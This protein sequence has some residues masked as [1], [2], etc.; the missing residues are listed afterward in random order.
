M[1][2]RGDTSRPEPGKDRAW[3]VRTAPGA[4]PLLGHAL[5]LRRD[6]LGFLASLPAHG[7]LV[8]VRLGP[9]PAYLVCHPELVQRVLSDA[10]TFD[11]GGPLFEKV[12]PLLGNGLGTSGWHDHRRQRR[13]MQPA[14]ARE[15]VGVHA[16]DM[17]HGITAVTDAW[18][19]GRTV[20]VSAAMQSVTARVTART[21]FSTSIGDQD[22][23]DIQHCLAVLFSGVYRRM[24]APLGL[25][26]KLP[27][28]GNRRFRA[29][30]D[31][32]RGLIHRIVRAHRRAA[33]G[34]DDLL[35]ALAAAHGDGPGDSL[36]DRELC[37]QVMTLLVAGTEPTGHAL[38]WAVHLIA[39]H[40]E[41]E[42]RLHAET[43]R[44]L[45]GR[46]L[47]GITDLP[48]LEYTGRVFTEVLRLYPPGWMFTRTTTSGTEL[49]GRALPRGADVLYSPY[50][51]HRDPRLFDEPGT[52]DPDRWH[53]DRA[54]SVPR[55]AFIP[56]GAGNRKCVGEH[57]G[58]VEA[59]L[60]LSTLCARWRLRPVPGAEVRPRPE[61][62]LGT[63]PLPMLAHPRTPG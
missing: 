34:H 9:R 37:D 17:V 60:A 52:F 55:G 57:F 21:L 28:P 16:A 32:L 18:Q 53:P 30:H 62:T 27:T 3:R 50:A 43:D 45:A 29:A 6:P 4:L 1:T 7:D 47:P 23:T 14:F 48:R 15:R 25:W 2:P 46:R 20:D 26:E 42:A 13:L 24:T 61:T 63:G 35:T 44:V 5:P 38:A 58:T 31:R 12:R 41:V 36:S 39:T 11:K 54:R 49:A 10:R 56:F 51:L 59:L 8:E 22:V 40:P 19:P 33:D